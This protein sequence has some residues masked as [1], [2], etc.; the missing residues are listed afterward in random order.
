MKKKVLLQGMMVVLGVVLLTRCTWFEKNRT[1]EITFQMA[2][3]E[4]F[5]PSR[6]TV[7]W[8]EK[9]DGTFVKTLFVSDYTAYGGYLV[10]GICPE[11][12]S[13]AQWKNVDEEEF[14]AVTGATPSE[15]KVS[16]KLDCPKDKVPDGDYILFMEVHLN[17]NFNVLCK[18]EIHV[19]EKKYETAMTVEYLPQKY[20]KLKEEYLS[21]IKATCK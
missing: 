18:G 20:P 3:P 12:V 8:L 17:E 11:W 9:P 21:D 1:L 6:Q 15:G 2:T 4:G 16:M 10:P 5:V 7:I 14:D 13:K 19:S